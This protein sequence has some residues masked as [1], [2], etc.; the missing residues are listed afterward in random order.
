MCGLN[1]DPEMG[2]FTN[3]GPQD[4]P[5]QAMFIIARTPKK[6]PLIF[7]TPNTLYHIL[8]TTLV[9]NRASVVRLVKW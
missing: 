7:G 8:Y 4:R 9:P 6:G 5:L 1:H 3:G 2:V